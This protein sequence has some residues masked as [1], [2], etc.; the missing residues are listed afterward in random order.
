MEATYRRKPRGFPKDIQADLLEKYFSFRLSYLCL[1]RDCRK[2]TTPPS[3]RFLGRKVY[4]A[5]AILLA[6]RAIELGQA[7][8]LEEIRRLIVAFIPKRTARRWI[9]WW[10]QAVWSGAFW[11]EWQGQIKGDIQRDHF[12]CGVWGHFEGVMRPWPPVGTDSVAEIA[13][14]ILLFFSPITRPQHYPS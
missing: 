14:R 4:V 7:V 10:R 11:R 2:R 12:L 13:Q 1:N 9:A 5:T 6:C 3:C 8:S